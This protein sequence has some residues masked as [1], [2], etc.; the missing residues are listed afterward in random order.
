[1]NKNIKGLTTAEVERSIELHG[2]NVLHKEKGKSFYKK[3]IEN[4]SDPI[5]KILI[6]ALGVEV[7]FTLGNCNYVEILGILVAILLSTTVSTAS[8]YRSECAFEKL[9]GEIMDA[10]VSVLRDGEIRNI[11]AEDLVIGDVVY[12]YAGEKIHADGYLIDGKIGVDQSA[13]NGESAECHK[14]AGNDD[15]WELSSQ[16][17]VFRGS[18]ITYGNAVMRVGRIGEKSYYGMVARDVQAETRISPLKLRLGKLA[19]QISRIGYV[20]AIIVKFILWLLI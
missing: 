14:S 12:L 4:L 20:M 15:G 16:H 7:I 17:T 1:M 11:S 9:N 19:T 6:I 3:F 8:E 5:I 18:I 10:K 2:R 13:L